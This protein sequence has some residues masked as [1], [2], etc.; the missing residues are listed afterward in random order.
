MHPI[1]TYSLKNK[2]KINAI[3]KSLKKSPR[4]IY[5]LTCGYRHPSIDDAYKIV[6]LIGGGDAEVIEL[7]RYKR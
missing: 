1:K 3:A 5:Q 2:I 4:Y 7:L 6:N